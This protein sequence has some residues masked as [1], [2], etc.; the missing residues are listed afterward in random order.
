MVLLAVMLLADTGSATALCAPGGC[1]VVPVMGCCRGDGL[2]RPDCC[3]TVAPRRDAVMI[4]AD[5]PPAAPALP[6]AILTA[7]CGGGV[8]LARLV[9]ERPARGSSHTLLAQ[10]TALL[11]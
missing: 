9:R 1:G 11:R 4:P 2:S 10:R 7:P 6:V 8:Q 3:P 5:P